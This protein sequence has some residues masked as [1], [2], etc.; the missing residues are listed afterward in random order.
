MTTRLDSSS[1]GPETSFAAAAAAIEECF[2]RGWSDGL[3]VVPPTAKGLAAMLAAAGRDP[4]EVLGAVPPGRGILTVRELALQALLAGC[5]PAAMPLLLAIVTAVLD[6]RFNLHGVATSTAGAAPLLIVNGPIRRTLGLNAGP[7][8]F[9]PGWRANATI[10]RTVRLLTRNVGGALPGELDQAA[11]AH[12]GRYA[13]CI[14]ENEE[15]SPWQ[16]LHVDRGFRVEQSVVTAFAAWAPHQ[17]ENNPASTAEEVLWTMADTMVGLGTTNITGQGEM[18]VL[19]SPEHAATVAGDGWS[20][21]DV[22]AFLWREAR[23]PLMDL[24]RVGRLS[25]AERLLAQLPGAEVDDLF[26]AESSSLPDDA[27][28]PVTR[29]PGGLLIMVAGGAVGKSSA[30]IPSWADHLSSQA[31]SVVVS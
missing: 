19:L 15:T 12:P 11:L 10:G 3:P 4:D 28:V 29:S 20:K 18:V 9:G 27:L 23:R 16:S 30:C 26:E 24:R 6:E 1:P 5:E 8:L 14:A 17:V 22:R 13:Y 21:A 31:V 2:A 7:S 25:G